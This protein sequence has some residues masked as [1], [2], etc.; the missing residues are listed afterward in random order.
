M[1]QKGFVDM[2]TNMMFPMYVSTIL[3]EEMKIIPPN[4][5]DISQWPHNFTPWISFKWEEIVMQQFF[6]V[7]SC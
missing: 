5:K 6:A 4:F 1:T 2:Y 7:P 3:L